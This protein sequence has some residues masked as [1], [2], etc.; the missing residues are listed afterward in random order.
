MY[1]VFFGSDRKSVRDRVTSCV[2]ES[3]P[4]DATL[5]TVSASEYQEGQVLGMLGASSLFGGEEW[6]LFDT[7]SDNADFAE[8][9]QRYLA[10][11]AE[12]SNTFIILEGVLLAPAKKKYTKF[13]VKM[14]E[15]SLDKKIRFN[16]FS[17]AEAL[18]NKDK[19]RLWILLQEA[20]L[21]GS[22]DE[23]IVGILWWQLKSLRLAAITNSASEA[24]VKDFPYSKSKRALVK[25]S[26]KEVDSLSQ[27][28]LELYHDGHSGLRNMGGALEQWVLMM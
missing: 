19:R 15:F 3:M 14:E 9:V 5:T 23:E 1:Q 11:L 25:F 2:D 17:L 27:S 8:A 10:D 7:P 12:S 22:R 18:A 6:F 20:R 21:S 4:K 28:L 16:T 13:S 24:G 26:D